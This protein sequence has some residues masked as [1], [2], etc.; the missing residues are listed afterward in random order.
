LFLDSGKGRVSG[1]C[2]GHVFIIKKIINMFYIKIDLCQRR[3]RIIIKW[4]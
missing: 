2:V 3:Q 1:V 4:Q